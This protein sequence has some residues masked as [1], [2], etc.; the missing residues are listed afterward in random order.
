MPHTYALRFYVF[1]STQQSIVPLP[2]TAGSVPTDSAHHVWDAVLRKFRL[3]KESNSWPTH[4]IWPANNEAPEEGQES[5]AILFA[6][7]SALA[8]EVF[9]NAF[10][11]GKNPLRVVE[12]PASAAGKNLA[13]PFSYRPVPIITIGSEDIMTLY[14]ESAGLDC[15]LPN[16][17][18]TW[19]EQR[20][21]KLRL[22]QL[23]IDH[24]AKFLDSSIWHRY[25]A[26]DVDF[27]K[28]LLAR[29]SEL[30]EYSDLRLYRSLASLASL[31]FQCRMLLHSFIVPLGAHGHHESVTP[32][33]FHSEAWAARQ[34]ARIVAF[35]QS[36]GE[37]AQLVDLKWNTLTVDDQA[38]EPISTT[39]DSGSAPPPTKRD[40]IARW[41]T[42]PATGPK[43]L[44]INT[45]ACTKGNRD[46]IG[47]GMARMREKTFDVV[48]LDYL[49]GK[50]GILGEKGREY[51]QE[52]LLELAGHE[53]FHQIRQGAL[54]RHWIF[55]ISSFP[56]AFGD[57]LRQLGMEG[58]GERWY[59]SEGG[60]P[61][62]TPELFRLNFLRMALLQISECYL[63]PAAML[64][65]LQ[66]F[67]AIEEGKEWAG[68][69][70]TA[71]E[72]VEIS[73]KVMKSSRDSEFSN[74][75]GKFLA[76]QKRYGERIKAL[77]TL[78]EQL[79]K[80]LDA[81]TYRSIQEEHLR[82]Q[83]MLEP[84]ILECLDQKLNDFFADIEA[85]QQAVISKIEA[86]IA[87]NK[88]DLNLKN[89]GLLGLPPEIGKYTIAQ[90]LNL[91]G[92]RLEILPTEIKNLAELA[93]LDLS[94]NDFAEIPAVLGQLPAL[95]WLDLRGNPRLREGLRY[96]WQGDDLKAML[97]Q[98]IKSK[99]PDD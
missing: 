73:Q 6:P 1:D 31:E 26:H 77:K 84:S 16:T 81:A 17:A 76:K 35:F 64:R 30:V 85:Q 89:L 23:G 28:N 49:L 99:S 14:Q 62:T 80:P 60:D 68:A 95:E 88:T 97:C 87:K 8:S 15:D 50:G 70:R 79:E 25:L 57:K 48:F 9:F 5:I 20:R 3:A 86:A 61:I 7:T 94:A 32:F 43:A 27:E 90:S 12:T 65:L 66:R 54:G 82:L 91:S 39:D 55:P 36:E 67:G 83:K 4:L 11:E 74:S 63:Y 21:E 45:K 19:W 56:F 52:F 72:F 10:F 53:S 22:Y 71:L 44:N 40:L 18:H 98:E 69:V 13:P 58:V 42:N 93:R 38:D 78:L 2:L 59:I 34:S 96:D 51:G 46:I 33:K 92:N 75:M 41:L 47:K 29:L 24:R 37:G